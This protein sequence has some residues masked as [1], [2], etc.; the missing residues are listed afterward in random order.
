MYLTGK[1]T[2]RKAPLSGCI[3]PD[4]PS[5]LLALRIK[6]HGCILL[7]LSIV[8]AKTKYFLPVIVSLRQQIYNPQ[9]V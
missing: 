2:E 3:Y 4:V 1:S 5:I 9:S 8:H 7:F 6:Y